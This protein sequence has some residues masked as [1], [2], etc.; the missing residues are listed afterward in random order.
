MQSVPKYSYIVYVNLCT[1]VHSTMYKLG[2]SSNSFINQRAHKQCYV[3]RQ[4]FLVI[5]LFYNRRSSIL[6]IN[7][8][9]AFKR[10]GQN[11]WQKVR[12]YNRKQNRNQCRVKPE[13]KRQNRTLK[14][15]EDT[16]LKQKTKQK[17]G[18]KQSREILA[19]LKLT[20]RNS[21]EC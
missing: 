20:T 19:Q 6:L 5:L 21:G 7:F 13:N 18:R 16:T 1:K 9:K 3:K 14:E 10:H 4:N 17:R 2:K 12:N 15:R 8:S 11:T